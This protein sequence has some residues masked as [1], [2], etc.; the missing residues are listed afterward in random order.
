MIIFNFA[1]TL[2]KNPFFLPLKSISYPS[3]PKIYKH[4]KRTFLRKNCY[5]KKITLL[6]LISYIVCGIYALKNQKYNQIFSSPF[7]I[8]LN[9]IKYILSIILYF[10][11]FP[12]LIFN[13]T[14]KFY[15]VPFIVT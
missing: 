8:I 13:A 10:K 1:L 12:T 2:T 11:K 15:K 9:L 7:L 5:Y 3:K 6:P 14:P 4:L